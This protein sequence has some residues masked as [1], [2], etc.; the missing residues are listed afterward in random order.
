VTRNSTIGPLTVTAGV[1]LDSSILDG[2]P[3]PLI[4]RLLKGAEDVA[5]QDGERLFGEGDAGDGCYWLRSGLLK[6]SVSSPAGEKRTLAILGRGS[7]V[8][9][10]SMLDGLP[11][12]ANVHAI[13]DC[14]L[15]FV[16]RS[17]FADCLRKDP[18]LYRN[19]SLT[20][21]AR[22]R[23]AN[24]E[25]AAASFLPVKER[26]ART[27]LRLAQYLGEPT[28]ASDIVI[29]YRISQNDIAAMAGL[30]RE[31][32]NRTLNEWRRKGIVDMPARG[33]M[34]V[35]KPQLELELKAPAR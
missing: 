28:G 7:I 16:S 3:A 35:H 8:G 33:H 11:R 14:T 24:D 1:A 32:V 20:L 22:L 26:V 29:R 5:L 4:K 17:A 15:T 9:E 25:A 34:V 19:I 13:S 21:A 31:S 6:V 27:L 12:S 18:A 10:I 2:L 23:Q 30:A